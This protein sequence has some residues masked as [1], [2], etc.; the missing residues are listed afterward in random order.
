MGD[1]EYDLHLVTNSHVR[2]HYMVEIYYMVELCRLVTSI[3]IYGPSH[4]SHRDRLFG[5][6]HRTWAGDVPALLCRPPQSAT[7]ERP[8]EL[9]APHRLGSRRHR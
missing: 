1:V 7:A 3:L 8:G 4:V 2:I 6:R 9:S 5:R